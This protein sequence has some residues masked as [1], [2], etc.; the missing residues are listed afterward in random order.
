[1]TPH[2]NQEKERLVHCKLKNKSSLDSPE[3]HFYDRIPC[4]QYT[5]SGFHYRELFSGYFRG[6]SVLDFGI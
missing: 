3:E 4:F 1:M 2:E 6:S 5:V